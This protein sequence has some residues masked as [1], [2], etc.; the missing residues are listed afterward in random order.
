MSEYRMLEL[1]ETIQEGDEVDGHSRWLPTAAAGDVVRAED[2]GLYR[3]A[4]DGAKPNEPAKPEGER[5]FDFGNVGTSSSVRFFTA[6]NIKTVTSAGTAAV[7]PTPCKRCGQ[8]ASSPDAWYHW[9][10]D[11]GLTGK[12]CSKACLTAARAE[13]AP[14][15]APRLCGCGKHEIAEGADPYAA[16]REWWTR[17]PRPVDQFVET[18]M[19]ER[20]VVW[21]QEQMRA[22]TETTVFAADASG[23]D[24]AADAQRTTGGKT[25]DSI[26]DECRDDPRST[27]AVTMKNIRDNDFDHLLYFV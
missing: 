8:S 9:S 3:R 1:G 19:S 18:H 14:K 22:K 5:M 20:Y 6:T 10:S 4:E 27:M 11:G 17:V 13:S 23:D 7:D 26:I 16:H 2:V 24:V 21:A 25:L 12:Y 15:P